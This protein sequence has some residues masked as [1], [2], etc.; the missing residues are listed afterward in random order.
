MGL[1]FYD[2]SISISIYNDTSQPIRSNLKK[3]PRKTLDELLA[4]LHIHL[5]YWR[6]YYSEIKKNAESKNVPCIPVPLRSAQDM[7]SD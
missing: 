6:T 5:I 1:G 2:I 3:N 4:P 7:N